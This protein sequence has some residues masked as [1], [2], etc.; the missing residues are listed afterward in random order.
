MT[1]VSNYANDAT[2]YA[3]D[4]NL[5]SLII[6]LEHDA[7][8]AV[9]WFESNYMKMNQDKCHLLYSGH[10]YETFVNVGETKIWESKQKKL[11]GI[12]T[13]RDLKFNEYVLSQCKKAGKK[14]TALIRISKF[15]TFGQ[16]R[17]IMK[18]FIKSQFG[19][20]PLFGCFVGDKLLQG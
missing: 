19:Y 18:A 15:M 11:L 7:A 2:F 1:G 20:C 10:K 17:N 13:D 16:R 6:R 4:L 14:L 8:L 5:K 9:E 3:F 12:L